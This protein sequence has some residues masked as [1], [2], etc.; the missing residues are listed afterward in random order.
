MKM[1][2]SLG[3]DFLALMRWIPRGILTVAYR[4]VMEEKTDLMR[5]YDKTVGKIP[6]FGGHW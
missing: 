5:V 3:C 6:T 2:R 4:L 1:I